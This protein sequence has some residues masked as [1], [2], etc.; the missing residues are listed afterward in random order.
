LVSFCV[1][2]FLVLFELKVWLRKK[3]WIESDLEMR[4]CKR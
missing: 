3:K 1:F 4:V 2:R